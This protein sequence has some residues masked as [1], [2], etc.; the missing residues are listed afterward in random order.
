MLDV[1]DL[2]YRRLAAQ[3]ALVRTAVPEQTK[4][5]YGRAVRC[6]LIRLKQVVEREAK[7]QEGADHELPVTTTGRPG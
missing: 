4:I 6:A 7:L 2:L 3:V 5:D 1:E